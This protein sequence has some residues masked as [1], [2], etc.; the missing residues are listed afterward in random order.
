MAEEQFRDL[1]EA[2][3]ADPGSQEKLKVAI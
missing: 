3:D 2:I 1:L